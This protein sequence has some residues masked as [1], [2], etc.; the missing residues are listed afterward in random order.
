[1]LVFREFFFTVDHKS[2]VDGPFIQ[3]WFFSVFVF[4][5]KDGPIPFKDQDEFFRLVYFYLITWSHLV[6]YDCGLVW[7]PKFS[8]RGGLFSFV[9]WF[10]FCIS[11]SLNK[12]RTISLLFSLFSSLRWLVCWVYSV[13]ILGCLKHASSILESNES[14]VKQS[15]YTWRL[16]LPAFSVS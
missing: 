12:Y 5:L 1:M 16:L 4:S 7:S 9:S 8:L 15:L 13:L 14:L 3:K 6:V 2:D 10:S 11:T